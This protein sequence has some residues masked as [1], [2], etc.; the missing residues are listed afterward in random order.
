MAWSPWRHSWPGSRPIALD[1]GVRVDSLIRPLGVYLPRPDLADQVVAPMYDDLTIE[2]THRIVADNPLSFLNVVRSEI[3]HPEHGPEER[4]AMLAGTAD[5]LRR[6]L[7]SEVFD[8]YEHPLFLVC[9]LELNGHAQVGI[10]ADVAL[11][12]YDR[13]LVK[14]HEST[15]RGQEDRLVEYMEI[16]R[17]S[18]L[19]VFLIH[20]QIAQIDDIVALVVARQPT[21]D[22]QAD[23]Q[24]QMTV[25]VANDPGD[26]ATIEK[27]LAKLDALY[28]ADGHHRAAAAS[29]YAAVR[30]GGSGPGGEPYEHMTSVLFAA[31]QLVVHPY[32]R[33]ISDLGD[34][35]VAKLLADISVSF[36]VMELAEGVDPTPTVAGEFA[37]Y[38]AGCWYRLTASPHLLQADGVAGLDIAVLHEHL[39]DPL[40]GV[41]DPRTDPRIEVIPGTLGLDKL[42]DLCASQSSVGF[43][44]HPMGVEELLEVSDRGETM[45][46]KSTWFAPKLR[47]GLVV[48]LL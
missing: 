17:A 7:A 24:L 14:V 46:P 44:V 3:D 6:L 12:A 31:D 23:S 13:G 9:R 42:A 2:E 11:E 27:A 48:R 34:L 4:R 43:A 15:R 30:R 36:S 38:L 10:V 1:V 21:I 33:C 40:L 16:V 22:I 19:P 8:Y 35:S 25:W 26:V 18:F 47:S 32:N 29:R 41:T 28:I 5:R 37:M 39:L 20:R 45:P